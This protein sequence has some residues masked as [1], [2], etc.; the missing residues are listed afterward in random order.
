MQR[1]NASLQSSEKV[2]NVEHIQKAATAQFSSND[3]PAGQRRPPLQS[4]QSASSRTPL[5]KQHTM[6]LQIN[7][8][9]RVYSVSPAQIIDPR[10]VAN[11]LMSTV[12]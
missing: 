2:I 3:S 7:S 8:K 5:V 4:A 12:R 9:S 6:M 10:G 11:H 1:W